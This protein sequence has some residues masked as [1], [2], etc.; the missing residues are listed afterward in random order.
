MLRLA[1]GL[2][3]FNRCAQVSD[4]SHYLL[5]MG[6]EPGKHQ[7]RGDVQPC[8]HYAV[9]PRQAYHPYRG[10]GQHAST[11]CPWQIPTGGTYTQP[12]LHSLYHLL[13]VTYILCNSFSEC[14]NCSSNLLLISKH[15]C[16]KVQLRSNPFKPLINWV[17]SFSYSTLIYPGHSYVRPGFWPIQ[18]YGQKQHWHAVP[19]VHLGSGRLVHLNS[20]N[21]Y[22]SPF[23][24]YYC[25]TFFPLNRF[26][27][28][29]TV[30]ENICF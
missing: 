14:L 25:I 11:Q 18:L 15:I 4:Q 5:L 7:L 21:A 23:P 10:H 24:S 17:T 9:A 6:G 3:S 12:H 30:Q 2:L 13:K 22:M 1:N 16:F 29:T 27:I 19:G 26:S 28:W 20:S 8:G